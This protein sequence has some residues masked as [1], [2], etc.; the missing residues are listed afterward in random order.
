[1][2]V[3]TLHRKD[4]LVKAK[5]IRQERAA[6]GG[7]SVDISAQVAKA[8]S[9]LVASRGEFATRAAKARMSFPKDLGTVLLG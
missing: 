8:R 4:Q 2:K 9:R 6:E 3:S 1:M 7:R 5:S